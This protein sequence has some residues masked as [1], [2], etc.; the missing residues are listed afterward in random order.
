[1]EHV[2]A[3]WKRRAIKGVVWVAAAYSLWLLSAFFLQRCILFPRH[4]PKQAAQPGA[5]FPGLQKHW[6]TTPQGKVETWFMPAARASTTRPLPAVIFAHGN[7]ELIDGQLA[8]VHGYHRLGISVLLC[9]Y[10]GYG[11]SAGSPSQ[12]RI[13]ADHVRCYD[14]LAARDE[15]DREKIFFHG[16]SLGTGVACALAAK[17]APAALILQSPFASVS[18]MMAWYL[19]PGF[20]VRDPFDNEA[21]LKK[22]DRPVLL[23]HGERDRIVPY[24]HSRALHRVARQS[25]LST[26]G[27]GHND[28]PT[29]S[30]RFWDEIAAHLRRAGVLVIPKG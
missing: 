25:T 4:V 15:V 27:C 20:L 13:I 24:R 11:R 29:T 1:M 18:D 30:S 14:R 8:M 28:F 19:I 26:Y 5:G 10:R 9:E 22:L 17:R 6:L 23:M 7:A 2:P 3:I 21:V 12:Q 16:R